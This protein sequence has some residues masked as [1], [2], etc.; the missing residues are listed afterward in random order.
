M[1]KPNVPGENPLVQHKRTLAKDHYF[2][3]V[4]HSYLAK[5]EMQPPRKLMLEIVAINLELI[6]TIQMLID[7]EARRAGIPAGAFSFES[8]PFLNMAQKR[9]QAV[10]N[11]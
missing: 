6:E 9:F 11:E 5:S 4:I 8:E 1:T 2:M 3:K 7:L 10:L